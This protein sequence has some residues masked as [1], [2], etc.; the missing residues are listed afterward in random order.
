[1]NIND[2]LIKNHYQPEPASAHIIV[3]DIAQQAAL[4]VLLN[5]CPAGLYR[6]NA[7][8]EISFDAHGCLECGTCRILCDDE[9]FSRWRY[10]AAGFGVTFRFG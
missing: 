1:M 7:Q 4:E 5:A 3:C 8:G 2:K 9:T 10:P 6:K